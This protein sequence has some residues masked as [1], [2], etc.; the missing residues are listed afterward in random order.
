LQFYL[1]VKSII[2]KEGFRINNLDAV[3]IAQEP[4]LL[5]YKNKI[6]ENIATPL[7]IHKSCVNIKAKTN[8][9]LDAVGNKQAIA[10][11]VVATIEK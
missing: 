10:C 4:S 11:Y 1:A 2:E 3:I 9:G 6:K 8:E 7:G 5:G